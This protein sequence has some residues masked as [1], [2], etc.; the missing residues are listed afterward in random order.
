MKATWERYAARFD[1]LQFRERAMV[2]AAVLGGILL[3]GHVLFVEPHM[4]RGELQRKLAEKQ[5]I[6]LAQI[7]E[8]LRAIESRLRDPDAD[9]RALLGRARAETAQIDARLKGFE[10]TLVPPHKVAAL[11][12]DLLKGNRG[13]KLVSLR[14]LPASG[15]IERKPA[16]KTAEEA[17]SAPAPAGADLFKHGVEIRIQ[18]GY[19]D[20]LDY[21][22]RTEA[23]SG[24]LFWN[25]VTLSV[26]AYPRATLTLTVYTM[27]LDKIWLVV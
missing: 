6:E 23:L 12:E 4:V 27:S 24:Q 14:T 21:L 19:A 26:N 25:G 3:L 7:E 1:A 9:G 15:L 22:A 11:L 10:R 17:A 2:V 13:L 8:Q 5:R 20:L 18:G 16:A